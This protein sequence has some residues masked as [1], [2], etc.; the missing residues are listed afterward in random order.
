MPNRQGGQTKGKSVEREEEY[1]TQI[2][3]NPT[4]Q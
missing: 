1:I 3:Q 4:L 2:V